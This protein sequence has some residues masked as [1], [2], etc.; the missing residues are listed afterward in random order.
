MDAEL[1]DNLVRLATVGL[2]TEGLSHP[3]QDAKILAETMLLRLIRQCRE[4]SPP[5][6]GMCRTCG[7]GEDVPPSIRQ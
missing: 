2:V 6:C 4:L 5:A 3:G 1:H 7:R